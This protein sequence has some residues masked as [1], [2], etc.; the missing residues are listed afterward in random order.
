[1][2]TFPPTPPDVPKVLNPLNPR[3]YWLLLKWVYFQP[4]R[5]KHYL[6][7]PTPNFIKQESYG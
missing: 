4:S 6:L 3:H 2:P 7:K 5:L 1:M